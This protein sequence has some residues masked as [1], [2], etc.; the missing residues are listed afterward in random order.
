MRV[1]ILIPVFQEEAYVAE[2]LRRVF[3]CPTERV[4]FE[5]EVLLCDDGSTDG[6]ARAIA[7]VARLVP[8]LRVMSH[9]KNRGKG[10]AIRTLLPHATGDCVLIQDADLEY[11]ADDALA[12][13]SAFA[14]GHPAV[15]GSRFLEQPW[16]EGM[17]PTNLV[18]NRV[19]TAT[20]NALYGHRITDEATC[21]KLVKTSVLR[22]MNLTCERFEFC[23]E[24]TAKLGRMD[25]PIVE[26]PVRYRARRAAQ[27]KKITWKDGFEA[28]RVLVRHRFEAFP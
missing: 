13:L 12:L 1:S 22:S 2:T 10:A 19:L 28:M 15:Y 18:A 3:A 20:A 24:V 26:V 14:E 9:E 8:D 11:D 4:G 27:G 23:P 25:V 17:L 6:T 7:D 21:L 16:P 5:R